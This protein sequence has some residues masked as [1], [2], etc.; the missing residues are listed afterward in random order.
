[1]MDTASALG[2]ERPAVRRQTL[3]HYLRGGLKGGE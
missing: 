3:S 1:M 2:I